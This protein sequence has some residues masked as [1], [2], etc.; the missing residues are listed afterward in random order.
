MI[1][2]A[3]IVAFFCLVVLSATI[4]GSQIREAHSNSPFRV[5]DGTVEIQDLDTA[6]GMMQ[7]HII[8]DEETG[9]DNFKDRSTSWIVWQYGNGHASVGFTAIPIGCADP[10]WKLVGTNN[11]TLWK[12][13][14]EKTLWARYQQDGFAFPFESFKL[15]FYVCSNETRGFGVTSYIPNS[16]PSIY[17]TGI[18]SEELPNNFK[19]IDGTPEQIRVDI[20]LAPDSTSFWIGVMLYVLFVILL[21]LGIVLFL[22][23]NKIEL[24]NSVAVTSGV[25]VFLP[26]LIFAFRTSIA[27]K[28]ITLIDILG[29]LAMLAFGFLLIFEVLKKTRSHRRRTINPRLYE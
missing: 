2:S 1:R 28:Y 29:F 10:D 6:S 11:V 14:L 20:S 7:L 17:Q 26:I 13:R 3:Q 5:V 9:S 22:N 18:V 19:F 21:V 16:Y 8:F 27:P 23:T 4:V 15:S 12:W 25:L 24:S